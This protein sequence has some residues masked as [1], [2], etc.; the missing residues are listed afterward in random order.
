VSKQRANDWPDDSNIALLND[1]YELTMAASYYARGMNWPA[2]FDLFIRSLP[3]RRN[4]LVACG[5]EQA[6]DFLEGLHF[7]ASALESLRS[8]R[9][10]GE[11]FISA[12]GGMRFSGEVWAVPE[13]E[14]VFAGEP[15]LRVTAPLIEA[16]LVET[17]LLNRV[18][19]QTM[20]ASKATR[21]GLA[22]RGKPFIDFSPRRD[23]GADAALKAA[24]AAFIAGAAGTSNVLAGTL[25]GIPVSGTMAHSYVMS[26]EDELTAFRSFAR[27]FPNRAVLLIDT[28]DIVEGARNAVRA[29]KEL[30]EQGVRIRAVRIDAGNLAEESRQVR[31][32]LDEAGLKDVE[33]FL[34]GDLD[35]Y[36]ISRLLSEGAAADAFGVGTHLGTSADAPFLSSVYKLV[37]DV[38]GPKMKLSPAKASLPG[39]KQIFRFEQDGKYARDVIAL[40]DE[41]MPGG[42]PLLECVMRQGKRVKPR[43]PLDAIRARCASAMARL[44]AELRSLDAAAQPYPLEHSPRLTELTRLLSRQSHH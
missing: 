22:C 37:D 4:F 6:L 29:A 40:E 39:R 13:G 43:E 30:R 8:L 11:S 36:E 10:F 19:F 35:E 15:L 16:Q 7:D 20:I 3:E 31:R 17:F 12:L 32:I 42:A 44:P 21:I 28:Y 27:D 26:F 14:I 33:I 1:L 34:S 41:K 18:T 38:H 5:L 2:T 25:Y 9:F 24:R 23:H